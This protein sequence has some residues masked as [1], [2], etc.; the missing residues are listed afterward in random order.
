LR[1]RCRVVVVKVLALRVEVDGVGALARLV[2]DVVGRTEG[3]IEAASSEP[4]VTI[5]SRDDD[6]P[7]IG[8]GGGCGW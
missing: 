8:E 3:E 4:E 7:I 1:W 2:V 6:R 5:G